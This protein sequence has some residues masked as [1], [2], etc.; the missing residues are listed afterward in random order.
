MSSIQSKITSRANK[1]ENTTHTEKKNLSI[2]TNLEMT[3]RIELVGIKPVIGTIVH[4]IKKA[5]EDVN[6]LR[7]ME[8][9]VKT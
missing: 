5:E 8:D 9:I 4:T 1:Q 6:I 3:Q 2:Y 7:D